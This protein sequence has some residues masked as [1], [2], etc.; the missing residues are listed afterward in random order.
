MGRPIQNKYINPYGI[1]YTAGDGAQRP[2]IGGE[3]ISSTSGNVNI[4][5]ITRGS[6]Y[7]AGTVSATISSKNLANGT[8]ATVGTVYLFANGAIKAVQLTGNGVGYTGPAT[9]TFFGANTGTATATVDVDVATTMAN[10]I[11]ANCFFTGASYGVTTADILK[12][13]GARTFVVKNLAGTSETLKLVTSPNLNPFSE[14]TLTV[15]ATFADDSQ[16]NVAKITNRKVYSSTGQAYKWTLTTGAYANVSAS[17]ITV[18]V[19]SL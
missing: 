13:R 11:L 6:G 19:S 16:F 12:A 2:G 10:A 9:L 1:N 17:N 7:S 18:V 14:G 8:N 5:T 4:A 15:T 3:G